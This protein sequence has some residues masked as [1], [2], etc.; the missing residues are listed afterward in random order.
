MADSMHGKRI[1]ILATDGF[2]QVELTEPRKALEKA[3]A[4][5][6]VVSPKTGEIKG[7]KFRE[8]GDAVKV[9]KTLDEAEAQE[10]DALLLPGG[11]I[12]PRSSADGAESGELRKGFCGDGTA[13]GGDLPWAMDAGGSGRGEREDAHLVAFP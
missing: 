7:W 8:W 3:G 1:A 6:E 9:D 11:V 12:N 10:Y 2:E 13:G 5:T 4:T